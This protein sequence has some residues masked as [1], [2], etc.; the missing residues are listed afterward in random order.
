MVK[1]SNLADWDSELIQDL[2]N[3]LWTP[4]PWRHSY[5]ECS[6]TFPVFR[7]SS[8]ITVNTSWRTK[9]G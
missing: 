4:P 6:Q 9:M 3:Q 8:G 5:D 1:C 2:L 7:H